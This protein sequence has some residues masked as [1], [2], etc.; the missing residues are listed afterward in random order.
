MQ[1]QF[2]LV[3]ETLDYLIQVSQ[4][5]LGDS[6]DESAFGV[7]K[8]YITFR[9]M[10]DLKGKTIDWLK[11]KDYK[12][13]DTAITESTLPL[14]TRLSLADKTLQ[15]LERYGVILRRYISGNVYRPYT[16]KLLMKAWLIINKYGDIASIS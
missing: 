2:K 9:V 3:P 15:G 6:S 5:L 11:V 16:L 13:T 10:R 4:E 12:I 14:Q 7:T 1:T 8:E